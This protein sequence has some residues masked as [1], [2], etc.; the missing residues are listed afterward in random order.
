MFIS[1][2]LLYNAKNNKP[3]NSKN[4]IAELKLDGLR[5]IISNMDKLYVYTRQNDLITNKFPELFN[6]PLPEGTILDGELIVADD[7][8][9]PDFEAMSARFLSKKNKTPVIFCAFDILRYKGI[10]V[11]GLSLLKRKELLDLAFIENEN[12]KKVKVFEG[13]AVDYFERARQQRLDGIIIKSKKENSIYEIEKRSNQWQ[14]VIN[15]TY[16]EVYIS[17]YR[18]NN[19]ALLASI[20]A[21]DGSKFPVGVIELGV[22]PIHKKALDGVKKRLVFKEDKNFAYMEPRIMARIKTRNW[23]KSGKLRSPVFMEFVI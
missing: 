22:T 14:K 4:H 16:A 1:P 9:K 21:A 13:N 23:T 6:C 2:M 10:D 15:W 12:Y 5:C 7:Q 19:F 18:K 8:G 3:F 20:D 17:G 11:T